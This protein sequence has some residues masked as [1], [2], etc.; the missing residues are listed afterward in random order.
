MN[1]DN[2]RRILREMDYMG[3]MGVPGIAY[4]MYAGKPAY[5]SVEAKAVVS[6][7]Y[8]ELGLERPDIFVTPDIGVMD[9]VTPGNKSIEVQQLVDL[10]KIAQRL[11]LPLEDEKK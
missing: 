5:A 3:Y 9:A 11:V 7:L 4:I 10:I 1:V 2:L 6:L 8:Q